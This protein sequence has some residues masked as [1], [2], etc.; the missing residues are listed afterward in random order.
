MNALRSLRLILW[1][2]SHG[3][4]VGVTI[5]GFPPGV[6]VD[7]DLIRGE[8]EKR[9]PGRRG[10]SPRR[11]PDDFEIA[12]GVYRGYTTGAPITAIIR[13]RDVDSRFYEQVY[14]W[15]PRP[16]HGDLPLRQAS[17]GF[18]DYRGA[19][20]TSGRL[21]A[22]LVLAGAL[23]RLALTDLGVTVAG[24]LARLGGVE[25][26]SP[27][28]PILRDRVYASPVRCPDEAASREMEDLLEEAIRGGDSLGG[29]VEARAY[30]VPPGL[31]EPPL[32]RL[33]ASLA[34]MV[35]SIPG[36]KGVEIGGGFGLTLE[37]GSR[38]NDPIDAGPRPGPR[39]SRQG[40]VNAGVSNGGVVVVRAAV[41]PTST[42]R[43]EQDSVDLR[44]LEP[45]RVRGLGR[46]DPAIALRAV[47]VV[48]AAVALVLLDHVLYRFGR[49][50]L[51][52]YRL[53]EPWR[54]LLDYDA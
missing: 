45:A 49:R 15:I 41:K 2:E 3:C 54:G 42:V 21:T 39:G 29:V 50:L 11:E 20:H 34:W 37:R 35:M 53:E 52:L 38:A 24:Y 13:N 14:R 25:C 7:Y 47:P 5:E 48:E 19:G 30:N 31:G 46:H 28:D 12:S 26:P 27:G 18:H 10:T 44:T 40:G 22:G 17:M 1:G 33:D 8:L 23:A 6:R 36:V 9:K 4:C 16:G 43:V 32:Y 51:H